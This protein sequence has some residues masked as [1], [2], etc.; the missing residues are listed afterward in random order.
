[1]KKLILFISILLLCL[2][3]KDHPS[4][5]SVDMGTYCHIPPG[6]GEIA[7]PNVLLLID[8]SG[9]M[10]WCA[11]N[12]TSSNS[13]CCSNSAGCGWTYRD[14]EEGYFIP[15]K[16][17]RYN[18]TGSYWE[19]TTGTAAS[20]PKI[21]S[22]INTSNRYKGSCLNFLYMRRIDLLRWALTGGKPNS[23][24]SNDNRKCN[25]ET[26][27]NSYI[28]CDSYG[29]ILSSD[30]GQ[31][32]K[33]PWSRITGSEGGLLFQVKNFEIRPR[34]G[35]MFFSANG[36]RTNKTYIGDFTSSATYDAS[37]PYK[38][39]ITLI[40]YEAPSGSTPIAPALWDAYNYFRQNSPQ[41]GGFTPNTGTEYWR[42]PLYQCFDE[43]NDGSCQSNELKPVP[44]A[45]NFIILLTDGQ[46][47]RGGNP[48]NAA[49][50]IDIGYESSSADP[51]VPAYWL[52][53]R[54]FNNPVDGRTGTYFV[55]SIYGIGLWLG[56]TGEKSLKHVAM[57]GSF[58]RSKTWPGNLT[59]YPRTNTCTVDDCCSTSNCGKGS[60]CTSLP[61]S[62][63][64]WDKNGD[65]IPDTFAAAS[66]AREVKAALSYA[67]SSIMSK[68]SS[69]ATVATLSSRSGISSLILQPYYYPKVPDTEVQWIGFLR[70]FWVDLTGNIREDSLANKILDLASGS[71]D[72]IIQFFVDITGNTKIT[73]LQNA[74]T[75][76]ATDT[77]SIDEVSSVFNSGC[78][79]ANTSP[80]DRVIKFN[81]S[82][83]LADFST[84]EASHLAGVWD[85][86]DST[87]NSTNA[88]CIVRYLRGENLSSDAT[89]KNLSYVKRMRELNINH[90]C[91]SNVTKTWKLGDIIH[92]TPSVT[93]DKPQNFYHLR[94]GDISYRSYITSDDYRRRASIAYVGANDGMLHAFRIGTI[95]TQA[96]V[97][98]PAKL[99]NSPNDS[100]TGN[101]SK[102][103]WAF[104]PKNALPYLL[105]YGH[106]DYCHIPTIDY[107]TLIFDAS[108][109]GDATASKTVSSWRTILV[110]V[111][112][113]GGKKLDL[114]SGNIYSSS[115]F[116]LDLTDWLNGTSSSPTLLWEAT[117]PDNTLTTSFPTIVR[118]GDKNNNGEWY[119]VIGT[120]PKGPEALSYENS[121][122]IYFYN[123]RNGSLVKSLTVNVVGALAAVGDIYN[124]D[125]DDDYQ[126]DVIYFGLYG[127]TTTDNSWGNFYKISLRSGSSYKTISSLNDSHISLAVNLSTFKTGNHQPPVFAAPAFTLDESSNLWIFLGT[128]KFLNNN[129]KNIPYMNYLIGYKDPFWNTT[130]TTV[131]K[132][133]LV[134]VKSILTTNTSLYLTERECICDN[135]GCSLR[136]INYY[137]T[138]L[139]GNVNVNT[140]WYYY[141]NGEAIISQ[142]FL[143]GELVNSLVF[144]PPVNICDYSGKTRYIALHYKLLLEQNKTVVI[145]QIIG[146]GTPPLGQPFQA[147]PSGKLIVQTSAGTIIKLPTPTVL[148]QGKF[149]TWIEK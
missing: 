114:G 39:T 93:S 69:G 83:S 138:Q 1:M 121:A 6:V 102:E 124:V 134:N 113:F 49:C 98:Q 45:K 82:G 17:Y 127:K 148:A 18:S 106:Y 145:D 141:L 109:N 101:I 112:G 91:G 9:S 31:K 139:S 130:G 70:A 21:A 137:K 74:S 27:P 147:L 111:M 34:F 146:A 16:I 38:N 62:S 132:A 67:I 53:K 105:W 57:Y 37:N 41:Y 11:Y 2:L 61:P 142:P 63:T 84:A 123:L 72:R 3:I 118:L 28:S 73:R 66:N 30:S 44:C 120:G 140:G 96:N 131:T 12:P 58:D 92:S 80:T 47:N 23:C 108:I 129:D 54:G 40:N 65:G 115:I 136:D 119:V 25:P 126:D 88:A 77:V 86:I 79:L 13:D 122:K 75:C 32:V 117:L 43:N 33:V 143:Y 36:I 56:G 20:C 24:D 81:K 19:E 149:I 116:V 97:N 48:V 87:I 90:F 4:V 125:V 10:S 35:A 46:W 22:G 85:D 42:N 55:D 68:S 7:P 103:E 99:Q 94:Y 110:G 15:D 60:P 95:K 5:E 133:D 89:C 78:W 51:V 50:S 104:I 8:E 71:L 64:D 100:G 29:C 128:G 144:I 107:R 135:S 14:N 52:H 26:Y 76:T 59:D